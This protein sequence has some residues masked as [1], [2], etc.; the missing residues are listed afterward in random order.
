MGMVMQQ[1]NPNA[2]QRGKTSTVVAGLGAAFVAAGITFAMLS[3]DSTPQAST[4]PVQAAAPVQTAMQVQ[5]P[6]P[7]EVAPPAQ[8]AP[9]L[10][11]APPLAAP[12]AVT[13]PPQARSCQDP[14]R[15]E[16]ASVEN[17]GSGVV[18]FRAGD[19]VS[20]WITLTNVPQQIVFPKLRPETTPIKEDIVLE[21]QA[22]NVVLGA[23]ND[24]F[25]IPK[26]DGSY[27]YWVRWSPAKCE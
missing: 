9:P 15:V 6:A 18:R 5:P 8:A 21:G 4:Q 10:Q 3:G 22:T 2:Q 17:G 26:V 24:H 1:T 27:D 7:I 12:P 23:E 14:R 13:A 16:L 20:P 19:Y 11:S 25:V